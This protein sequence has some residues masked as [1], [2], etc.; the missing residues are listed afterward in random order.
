MKDCNRELVCNNPRMEWRIDLDDP[1]YLNNWM[2]DLNLYCASKSKVSLLGSIYFIAYAFGFVLFP[3][4]NA[5]ERRLSY[6]PSLYIYVISYLIVL[7][8]RNYYVV[9]FGI[10]IM[11]FMHI[12]QT[13]GYVYMIELI[14]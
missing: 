11:G 5:S 8:S 4:A 13:L 9:L 3:L 10:C 2:N 1:Y 6:V 12:K 14:P 7:F